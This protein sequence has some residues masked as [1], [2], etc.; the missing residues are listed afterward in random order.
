M[1]MLILGIETSCDETSAAVVCDGRAVRSNVVTSQIALHERYGGVVPE[2]AA[3]AHIEAIDHIIGRALATAGIAYGDV[4]AVAV[5]D[6]PGLVGSLLVGVTAAK[7]IAMT[8]NV[9][10][11]AVDHLH[12][13]AV[14]AALGAE[15][16]WPAVSLVVSGGH[17]SL[18]HVRD[19]LDV[20]LIGQ[21][22]DDAAG[23]AFDKVA[24][25]LELGFP[26]GPA[27]ERLARQG[28]PRAIRFPRAWL[29]E[30]HFNFSYS[31]L[32][33]A[34]LYHV[35]GTGRKYGSTAHL[36]PEERAD[37]AASFQAALIEPLVVKSVAAAHACGV[38][39]LTLGGGVASNAAL[40][41]ALAR[42]CAEAGLTLHATPTEYCTD[43][44][45]MIAALGYH[46]LTAGQLADLWLE[47]RA[48][49]ARARR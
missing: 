5:T 6:G 36:R 8:L 32:K 17:T 22:V 18:Y 13:H 41:A 23:E 40:R 3:R 21:T 16:P 20:Q 26:G 24:A 44:A 37:I 39:N 7:T 1:L 9:P 43:N 14:S 4:D 34:V 45:A 27:V 11:V 49:L 15:S 25:I 2:I 12:A 48:G 10:L 47:P 46:K 29:D 35:H 19:F 38:R 31:G 42:A 28:D 33:T 30:A